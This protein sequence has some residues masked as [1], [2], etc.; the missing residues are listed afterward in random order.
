MTEPRHGGDYLKAAREEA[1][2]RQTDLAELTGLSQ[3]YLSQIERGHKPLNVHVA[4]LVELALELNRYRL[5]R[6]ANDLPDTLRAAVEKFLSDGDTPGLL[7]RLT[8]S[9]ATSHRPTVPHASRLA[10]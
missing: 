9:P 3:P 5:V 2:K 6:W 7:K 8:Y 1:Q 10:A 4:T